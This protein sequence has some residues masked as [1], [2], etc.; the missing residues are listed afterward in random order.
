[1]TVNDTICWRRCDSVCTPFSNFDDT[2]DAASQLCQPRATAHARINMWTITWQIEARACKFNPA[3][4]AAPWPVPRAHAS[5]KQTLLHLHSSKQCCAPIRIND[6]SRISSSHNQAWL[7]ELR[8]V[9]ISVDRQVGT[10][11]LIH[12]CLHALSRQPGT[13]TGV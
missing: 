4:P 9:T 12:L 7:C 6:C 11:Y 3:N 13:T 10:A 1:M 5:E 2:H 8:L